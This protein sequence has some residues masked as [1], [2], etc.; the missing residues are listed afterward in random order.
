MTGQAITRFAGA[1]AFLSN[2]FRAVLIW[3]EISYP[4]SE[5]AFHA[6]KVLDLEH[7]RKFAT[8]PDWQDAKAYG[9]TVPL[10][11]GWNETVRYQVMAEVLRAKFTAH[12]ERTRLL[13]S[14]GN[15]YLVEGNTWHDTH[16][17]VC[18]C[19]TH[20]AQGQNHLGRLL[21]ELREEL[22]G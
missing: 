20:Q 10:R 16:W 19:R 21:M 14:T 5:H 1:W 12:P 13:L 11:P 15:S 6:G 22:R 2:P 18:Y 3:E 9:Q 4:T 8:M 7:R 17:G